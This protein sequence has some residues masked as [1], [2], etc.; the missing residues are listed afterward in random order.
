MINHTFECYINIRKLDSLYKEDGRSSWSIH[1][2]PILCNSDTVAQGGGDY[3]VED[4]RRASW[5]G[6]RLSVVRTLGMYADKFS[7]VT[8]DCLFY[9]E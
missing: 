4:S 3:R 1:P 7:D 9:E 6:H 5:C 2:I 8:E